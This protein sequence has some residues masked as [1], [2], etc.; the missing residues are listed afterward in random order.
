MPEQAAAVET[1]EAWLRHSVCVLVDEPGA[2]VVRVAE[3]TQADL[4]EVTVAPADVPHILGKGG[5]NVDALRRLLHCL[6]GKARR[7]FHLQ[8]VDSRKGAVGPA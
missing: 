4:F 3:G 2:V 5:A 8:I 1:A 7:H 6:G